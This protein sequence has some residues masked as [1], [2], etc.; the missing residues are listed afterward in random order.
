MT[1]A[2]DPPDRRTHV[3]TTRSSRQVAVEVATLLERLLTATGQPRRRE[4]TF[5]SSRVQRLVEFVDQLD[6]Q[7]R[8]RLEAALHLLGPQLDRQGSLQG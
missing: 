4:D 1:P 3:T 6:V 8:M 5:A 7:Y 2:N